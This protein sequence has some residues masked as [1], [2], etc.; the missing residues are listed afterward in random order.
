MSRLNDMFETESQYRACFAEKY[1]KSDARRI[2]LAYKIQYRLG[3]VAREIDEAAKGFSRSRAREPK[4]R[5]HER[6]ESTAQATARQGRAL[7][8]R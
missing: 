6:A 8:K 5:A 4:A 2:L 1:L 7:A 3:K